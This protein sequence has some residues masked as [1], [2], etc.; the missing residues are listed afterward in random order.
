MDSTKYI[1]QTVIVKLPK[2]VNGK[3]LVEIIGK[4]AKSID[5]VGGYDVHI[6]ND[7]QYVSG[8]VHKEIASRTVT[9]MKHVEVDERSLL[10]KMLRKKPK[11]VNKSVFG[12]PTIE[13]K[14]NAE[15]AYENLKVKLYEKSY[16]EYYRTILKTDSPEHESDREM[17]LKQ[18]F[19]YIQ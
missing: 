5:E 14:V 2:K 12:S 18:L 9:L 8:S 11:I 10:E 16:E 17:F 3:E 6:N 13:V 4:V 19:N 1:E 15:K 7:M